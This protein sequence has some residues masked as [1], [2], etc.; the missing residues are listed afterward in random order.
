VPVLNFE[1]WVRSV[2]VAALSAVWM[3][4]EGAYSTLGL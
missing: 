1:G 4:A 2:A 3:L